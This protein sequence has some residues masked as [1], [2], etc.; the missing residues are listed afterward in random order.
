MPPKKES[1]TEMTSAQGQEMTRKMSARWIHIEKEPPVTS[2]G[3][4]ASRAAPMTTQGVYQR[5]KRVMKFS[6]FAFL[7]L[8]FSTRS[9]ILATVDSP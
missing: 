1:G 5:A 7:L 9:R 3:T 4:T 6:A 8:A 2:G